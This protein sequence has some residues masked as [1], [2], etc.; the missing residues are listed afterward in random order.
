MIKNLYFRPLI[1][2]FGLEIFFYLLIPPPKF[3]NPQ[4]S[5]YYIWYLLTQPHLEK[6]P[7][8]YTSRFFKSWL[9]LNLL[10]SISFNQNLTLKVKFPCFQF[11]E[12]VNFLSEA[13]IFTYIGVSLFTSHTPGFD[14]VFNIYLTCFALVSD[15]PLGF[16]CVHN[17]GGFI[18][19]QKLFYQTSR[20]K[21]WCLCFCCLRFS[22][23]LLSFFS[24][25]NLWLFSQVIDIHSCILTCVFCL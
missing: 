6:N 18:L 15:D 10:N 19:H 20:Q 24:T 3:E 5:R 12:A 2:P 23:F 7:L 9:R 21:S 17:L 13:F 14:F 22:V 11:F 8:H 16:R 25:V 1:W 4:S